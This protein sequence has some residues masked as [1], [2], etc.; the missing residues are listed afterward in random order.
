M[1]VAGERGY[2]T[3][4]CYPQS[5]QPLPVGMDGYAG[6]VVFGGP[7]SANDDN[8]LPGIRAQL[9]GFPPRWRP[10]ARFWGFVR[11][12]T[13]GAG[14]GAAVKP[15][16]AGLAEI[17]YFPVQPP[18]PV[19]PC[20]NPRCT[21]ITGT[22]KVSNCRPAPNL[23][24]AGERF[25]HQAYRYGTHAFQGAVS[26]GMNQ[27]N[28]GRGWWKGRAE[29]AAPGAQ[30]AIE[31][32]GH[33][34]RHDAAL[35]RWCDGF[36]DEWLRAGGTMGIA[37]GKPLFPLKFTRRGFSHAVQKFQPTSTARIPALGGISAVRLAVPSPT[38][39]AGGTSALFGLNPND[40]YNWHKSIAG[41]WRWH[42]WIWRK[43]TPLPDWVPTLSPA[44]RAISTVTKCC[45][46][47]ACSCCRSVG[48][49]VRDGRWLRDRCSASTCCLIPSASRQCLRRL[50]RLL[51]FSLATPQWCSSPGTSA[52][53]SKHHLFDCDH[54]LYRMP[55]FRRQ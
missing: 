20:S 24:A 16:P 46:T 4:Y 21:S 31:Q 29:L 23:L 28:S 47:V 45:C 36:L 49:L 44:E 17:G 26:P 27:K 3:D 19:K 38:S 39:A 41:C 54:F 37:G 40:Y 9:T 1:A 50:A 51:H 14:T 6:A 5:G 7:M 10:A 30:S 48:F 35:D 55:P 43:T 18:P 42:G 53:A 13:T 52:S 12:A 25:L 8:K 33:H 22:A 32:R 15:H 11:R 2:Q 34:A